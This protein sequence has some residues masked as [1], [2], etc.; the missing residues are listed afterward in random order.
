MLGVASCIERRPRKAV[1]GAVL[2]LQAP[3]KGRGRHP[4]AGP[5]Q[6]FFNINNNLYT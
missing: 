3:L 1:F 4:F 5:C 2:A 6:P